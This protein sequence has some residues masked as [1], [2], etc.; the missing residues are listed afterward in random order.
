MAAAAAIVLVLAPEALLGPSFQ[1][2]FAAVIAL[3]AVFEWLGPRFAQWMAEASL[4][5]KAWLYVASVSVT[6][7]VA[8]TASAPFAVY[9]FGRFVNY[10]V[11]ANLVAVPLTT[12]WVMPLA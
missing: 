4:P 10:G 11:V 5:R 6:T 1:M 9:H 2:S 8:G 7:L 12:V 3:I